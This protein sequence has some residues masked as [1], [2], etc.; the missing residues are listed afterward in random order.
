MN[1]TDQKKEVMISRITEI[2]TAMQEAGFWTDS[3]KAQ[4]LVKEMQS[5]KE[6]PAQTTQQKNTIK[7]TQL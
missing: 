3:A 5:L 2:E 1:E 6:I 4:I 7:A